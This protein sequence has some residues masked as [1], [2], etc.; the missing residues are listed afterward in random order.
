LKSQKKADSKYSDGKMEESLMK[1]LF[2]NL[3]EKFNGTQQGTDKY[4]GTYSSKE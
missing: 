4:T 3:E 1:E 2:S